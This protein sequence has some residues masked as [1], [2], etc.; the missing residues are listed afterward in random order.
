MRFLTK[1]YSFIK[2]IYLNNSKYSNNLR[3]TLRIFFEREVKTKHTPTLF[4]STF[5]GSKWVDYQTFNINK[6]FIKSGLSYF[7]YIFMIFLLV[8]MFLGRSKSE[9]YFG[10]LPLFSYVNFVLGYIPLVFG[11]V[12]SQVFFSV[13]VMYI[14]I[15]K[16]INAFLSQFS[17]NLL[18][19]LDREQLLRGSTSIKGVSDNTGPSKLFTRSLSTVNTHTTN[20]PIN[21]SKTLSNLG[22]N[23]QFVGS[24]PY[25]IKSTSDSQ[26]STLSGVLNRT[27]KLRD[28]LHPDTFK[29]ITFSESSYVYGFFDDNISKTTRTRNLSLNL[30]TLHNLSKQH[31]YPSLF[32]FKI[33]NNLNIAKQ[34]RWL[35]R[36]SLISE[37][38]INNSFLV[39]QAK[40]IIGLGTLNKEYTSKS[41]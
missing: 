26:I 23:I 37:S 19:S 10:F 14:S 4:G 6:L 27:I 38:I 29:G 17:S 21:F 11:D 18:N 9:Q 33:E 34:Q 12:L 35:V 41:L 36:N 24:S 28:S 30:K 32:D 15:H 40:K 2:S 1:F 8:I 3:H 31:N 22:T 13:Y 20:S 39:T 7:Y 25:F 16:L 5:K